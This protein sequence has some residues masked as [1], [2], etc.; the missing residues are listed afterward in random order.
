MGVTEI[1]LSA[2][3]MKRRLPLC[4]HVIVPLSLPVPKGRSIL[5]LGALNI[6]SLGEISLL[7]FSSPRAKDSLY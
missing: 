4:P 1:K 5:S 3:T 6:Y 7:F 2:L